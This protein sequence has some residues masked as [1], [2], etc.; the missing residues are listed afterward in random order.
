MKDWL[1]EHVE[2]FTIAAL[3]FS[4]FLWMNGK[5]NDMD[6]EFAVVKQEIAV[7]KTVLIMKNIMPTELA[8]N[9]DTLGDKGR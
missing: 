3:I 1:K 7:M 9:G 8:K 5:F 6:K 4:G 2:L